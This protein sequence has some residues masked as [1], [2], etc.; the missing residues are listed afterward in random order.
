VF[1]LGQIVGP[2]I[3]GWIADGKGGL[4]RGLIFS[5]LALFIGSV[6]ASQQKS[7]KRFD[8]LQGTV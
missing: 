1:A 6:L 2:T 7:L 8:P 4:E 3:V 5:A